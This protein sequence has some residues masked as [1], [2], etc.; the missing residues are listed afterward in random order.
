MVIR[1]FILPECGTCELLK[2]SL[3]E[4]EYI[5]SNNIKIIYENPRDSK[6]SK[7]CSDLD[8][9]FECNHYP[10]V[11]LETK[12]NIVYV[13]PYVCKK[14]EPIGNNLFFTWVQVNEINKLIPTF[15]E[16]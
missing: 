7:I 12:Q 5:R 1:V 15:Y 3:N 4:D 6:N 8:K 10:K 11:I 2:K 9:I 13:V 16:K 14:P